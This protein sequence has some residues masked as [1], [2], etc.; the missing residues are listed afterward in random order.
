MHVCRCILELQR[1]R[2]DLHPD[3]AWEIGTHVSIS[4]LTTLLEREV[5]SEK[6][7]EN[8]NYAVMLQQINTFGTIQARNGG[9]VGSLLW[10]ADV[11]PVLAAVGVRV[12][13]AKLGEEPR[14]ML[15]EEVCL[16][17]LMLSVFIHS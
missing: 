8:S 16:A 17:I 6:G 9:V 11:R 2:A 14:R 13:V 1:V 4:Q 3:A 15:A 10:A 5:S 12:V 7:N